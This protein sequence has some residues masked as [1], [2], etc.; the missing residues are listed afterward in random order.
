MFITSFPAGTKKIEKM[1]DH[2]QIGRE[3]GFS[4]LERVAN[5]IMHERRIVGHSQWIADN[6]PKVINFVQPDKLKVSFFLLN[7]IR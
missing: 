2:T 1:T 3:N 6:N 5:L 4:F 7:E